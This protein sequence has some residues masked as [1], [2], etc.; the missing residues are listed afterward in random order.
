[1]EYVDVTHEDQSELIEPAGAI[2]PDAIVF[3]KA[4]MVDP[5]LDWDGA[6]L[7][8]EVCAFYEGRSISG[9]DMADIELNGMTLR[10]GHSGTASDFPHAQELRIVGLYGSSGSYPSASNIPSLSVTPTGEAGSWSATWSEEALN[11]LNAC[12]PD[13]YYSGFHL[14]MR[15]PWEDERTPAVACEAFLQMELSFDWSDLSTGDGAL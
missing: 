12:A 3:S 1:M 13:C 4:D 2:P 9:A 8:E 14:E 6:V 7:H 11:G 10:G 15:I 5:V